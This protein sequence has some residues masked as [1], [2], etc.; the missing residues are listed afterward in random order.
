[1]KV[2]VT[3]ATGYLGRVLVPTLHDK[4]YGIR[5]LARESSDIS[6]FSGLNN[7][8]VFHGDITRKDSLE[9]IGKGIEY[10]YHLAVL[11]HY[12]VVEDDQDYFDVN[13]TGSLN[14]LE[15]FVGSEVKK[16]LFTTTSGAL[17]AIPHRTVTEDDFRLPVTPYGMS[18][19]QAEL[20]IKE[21][22]EKHAIPYVV[23]PV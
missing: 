15:H 14:L 5:I 10:V 4:G 9:G 13:K 12:G 6:A 3:G 22:A 19:H 2:L 20:S 21:F 18:K 23:V 11:G 8:E 17:G 16:I 1:M 7:I